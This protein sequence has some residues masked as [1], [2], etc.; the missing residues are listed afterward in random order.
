MNFY[1]IYVENNF[2]KTFFNQLLFNDAIFF[3]F[4]IK[5]FIFKMNY[6]TSIDL[7]NTDN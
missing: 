3:L 5:F 2:V 4:L 1:K 6:F 7:I